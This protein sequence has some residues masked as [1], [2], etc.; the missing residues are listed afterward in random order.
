MVMRS[1]VLIVAMA[2]LLLVVLIACGGESKP[3][4]SPTATSAPSPT[5]SPTA[6][7]APSPTPSPTTTPAPVAVGEGLTSE[8]QACLIEALGERAGR[9]VYTG[10]RPP[11][12]DEADAIAGCRILKDPGAASGPAITPTPAASPELTPEQ[13]ACL[14]EAIGQDWKLISEQRPPTS[15]ELDAIAGC[16]IGESNPA[17][18]PLLPDLDTLPEASA[19]AG[20][21]TVAWTYNFQESSAMFGRLPSE[22]AG[23]GIIARFE[24]SGPGIFSTTYGGD[25][26]TT[27]YVMVVTVHDLTKGAFF[28]TDTNAGQFVALYAQGA[29][30]EVLAAGREG[31]LAWV[32][33]K[34]G[35]IYMMHWGNAPSSMVYGALANDL[36][37]LMAL[38]EAMVSVAGG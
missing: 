31:D 17:P 27:G 30:W 28:P 32:Q 9:E 20:L 29:D 37:E 21:G 13:E 16:G 33:W 38:V 4:A 1:S 26:E 19:P 12:S 5:S 36:G 22:I 14:V 7:S 35:P 24:Q 8:L 15:D 23:H 34:T 11:T 6:T 25:T 18:G 2:A 10:Q 3:T